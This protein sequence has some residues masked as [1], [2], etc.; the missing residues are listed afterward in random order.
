[1]K[2]AL[3]WPLSSDGRTGRPQTNRS[4][5]EPFLFGE[6]LKY[7][8]LA[9]MGFAMKSWTK[10]VSYHIKTGKQWYDSLDAHENASL[11]PVPSLF[12]RKTH[13]FSGL[14][15]A[16]VTLGRISAP[17]HA[18]I[19]KGKVEEVMTKRG[20]MKKIAKGKKPTLVG[21]FKYVLLSTCFKQIGWCSQFV[22]MI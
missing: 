1:M 8:K 12:R 20:T 22:R 17:S 14:T 13:Q 9:G 4:N 21:G 11:W 18:A 19:Q 15:I 16:D 3:L 6:Y 5:P 2:C 10:N 7:L